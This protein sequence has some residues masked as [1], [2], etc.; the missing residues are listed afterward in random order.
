MSEGTCNS[1]LYRIVEPGDWVPYGSTSVQLPS[2][3]DCGFEMTDEQADAMPSN[4]GTP[5]SPCP[6][7]RKGE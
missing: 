1:C 6:Y 4:C 5:E 3:L 7:W 2:T